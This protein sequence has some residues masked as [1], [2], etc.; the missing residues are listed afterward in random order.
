APHPGNPRALACLHA[1]SA[2][3][4]NGK[5]EYSKTSARACNIKRLAIVQGELN[6]YRLMPVG[7]SMCFSRY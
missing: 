7:L 2:S 1:A 5:I 4:N 3:S 6:H